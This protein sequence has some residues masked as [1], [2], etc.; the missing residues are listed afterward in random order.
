[1]HR[2][3]WPVDKGIRPAGSPE[4]CFYCGA[5]KGTEHRDKCTMRTRTVVVRISFDLCMAVPEDWD[6]HMVEFHMNE[7]SSCAD[8]RLEDILEQAERVGC[9]CG[10]AEGKYLREA[11]AED[12]ENF[13]FS[14]KDQES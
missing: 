5:A 12:E 9:S 11:T 1:M 13:K 2:N 6:T 14:V 10:F 3:N 4:H 7:S 8:N